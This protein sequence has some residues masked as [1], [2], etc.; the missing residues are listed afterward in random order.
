MIDSGIGETHINS[1]LSAIDIPP[2]CHKPLKKCE[3]VVDQALEKGAKESCEKFLEDGCMLTSG[4]ATNA[5]TTNATAATPL[6][7]ATVKKYR[8]GWRK[9]MTAMTHA[10]LLGKII[11]SPK[12][13]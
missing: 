7:P 9:V 4:S 6:S 8:K 10:M 12:R 13:P 3:R 1:V 5:T 11:N 2:V